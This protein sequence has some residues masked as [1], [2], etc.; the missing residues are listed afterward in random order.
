MAGPVA[1]REAADNGDGSVV[2]FGDARV[3]P[4]DSRTDL[5]DGV[6]GDKV[7]IRTVVAKAFQGVAWV[8]KRATRKPRD[9]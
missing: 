4:L 6:Q 7:G 1:S 2:R 9:A 5:E 8:F 3:R